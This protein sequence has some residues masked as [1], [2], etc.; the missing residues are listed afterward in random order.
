MRENGL[1]D[2]DRESSKEKEA[3][4]EAMNMSE[5]MNPHVA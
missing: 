5:I 2:R 4:G 1:A 3:A